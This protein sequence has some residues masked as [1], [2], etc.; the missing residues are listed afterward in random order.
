M[1]RDKDP[2]KMYKATKTDWRASTK[3]FR[4]V[5]AKEESTKKPNEKREKELWCKTCECS[6]CDCHWGII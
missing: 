6:P 3:S 2:K 4:N 1:E 5:K